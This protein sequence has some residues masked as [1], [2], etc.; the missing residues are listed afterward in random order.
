MRRRGFTLIELL[1][2]ISILALLLSLLVPSLKSAMELAKDVYCRQNLHSISL[3]F[4]QYA[5]ENDGYLPYSAWGHDPPAGPPFSINEGWTS[6]IERIARVPEDQKPSRPAVVGIW[7][8]GY[9]DY[10]RGDYEKGVFKCPT[11]NAQLG[12]KW[13][14]VGRWDFHYG[15]NSQICG[16]QEQRPPWEITSTRISD[17]KGNLVLVS[18][19]HL[20]FYGGNQWSKGGLYFWGGLH[21]NPWW[22]G[23]DPWP[24]QPN[25]GPIELDPELGHTGSRTNVARIDASVDASEELTYDDFMNR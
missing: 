23:Y 4:H 8:D 1:V 13:L 24:Q 2:V 5:V 11:A 9:I 15:M 20:G 22:H 7:R 3:A 12:P 14:A 17:V 18:D 21:L 16:A 10:N 25:A 6:W 19:A